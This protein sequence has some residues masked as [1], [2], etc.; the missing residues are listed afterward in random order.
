MMNMTMQMMEM[1]RKDMPVQGMDMMMMQECIEA[2][3]AAEQACT[4]CAGSTMG[5]G[6]MMCAN[7]CMNAA[8]MA[9]TTMRM[10]MRPNGMHLNSMIKMLDACMTMCA[11]CAD[12]CMDHADVS[13]DCRM[14]AEVCRQAA[15]ACQKMMES[16][17]N[18][19][20]TS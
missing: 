6:M 14:C 4:M 17:K 18:M 3:S 2:G 13:E 8:D 12:E 15:M 7:M 20:T 19:T 16:M 9:N 1:H 5:P 11:A 10:M